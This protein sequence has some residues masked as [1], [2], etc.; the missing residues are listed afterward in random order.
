MRHRRARTALAPHREP[1]GRRPEPAGPRR[2]GRAPCVHAAHA[3]R[4][5][6]AR[7]HRGVHVARAGTRAA[8]RRVC[9]AG[10]AL[11]LLQLRVGGGAGA[12]ARRR[13]GRGRRPHRGRA[14]PGYRPPLRARP[15][16]PGPGRH[17]RRDARLVH[18]HLVLRRCPRRPERLH[19]PLQLGT[20]G[21]PQRPAL[22]GPLHRGRCRDRRRPSVGGDPAACRRRGDVR[23]LSQPRQRPVRRAVRTPRGLDAADVRTRHPASGGLAAGLGRC[24]RGAEAGRRHPD[25]R[26]GS[27]AGRRPPH[28]G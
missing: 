18:P 28:H 15:R 12:G 9:T 13:E 14:R 27:G 1:R 8:A 4:R 19:V 17:R 2:T 23:G 16:R 20:R 25:R 11:R 10:S 7:R 26:P 6:R 3:R 21:R 22:P 5:T 24:L